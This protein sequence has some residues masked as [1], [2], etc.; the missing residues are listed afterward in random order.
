VALISDSDNLVFAAVT[1]GAL[2]VTA[3]FAASE[4]QRARKG[5]APVEG[6]RYA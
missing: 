1:Q 4:P 5:K 3:I 2:I 6:T